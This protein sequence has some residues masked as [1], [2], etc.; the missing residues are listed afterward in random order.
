MLRSFWQAYAAEI[1][2][3]DE[4]FG[5]LV[6][7]LEEDGALEQTVIA[8]TS[9]HGEGLY[10]HDVKGHGVEVWQEQHQIPMVIAAP[11]GALG[12]TRVRG[13]ALLS[14]LRGTL[15]RLCFGEV[16]TAGEDPQS[17]DLWG[18]AKSGRALPARPVWRATTS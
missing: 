13:P 6:S 3:T 15:E 5:R 17:V 2:F 8:L 14:D 4:Q 16:S 9:D 7:A 18:A 10:E 1:R 11:D 12:G